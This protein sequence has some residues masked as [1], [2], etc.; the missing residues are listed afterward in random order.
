MP[1]VLADGRRKFTILTIKPANPEAPTVTEL[2]AGIHLE[3]KVM[4]SDFEWNATGSDKVTEPSLADDIKA[5][6][7]GQGNYSV[8][9]SLWRYYLTAGGVDPAEDAAFVAVQDK[10]TTLWG[11]D[12]ISEKPATDAWAADDPIHLGG[13]F[14]VDTPQAMKDGWTKFRVPGEMQRAYDFIKAVAGA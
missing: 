9:F 11:Y 14:T 13:E 2:N 8:G 5:N 10:G 12:R 1:R 6:S 3:A 7:L 4:S